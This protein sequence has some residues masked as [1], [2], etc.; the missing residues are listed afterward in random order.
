[1]PRDFINDI[2]DRA[3]S[4]N[5]KI[6]L[7][8]GCGHCASS[9]DLIAHLSVV[10]IDLNEK[11]VEQARKIYGNAI[12]LDMKKAFEHF[13]EKSFDL[14]FSLD[15]LE[16]LVKEDSVK[17]LQDSEKIARN[18]VIHFIPKDALKMVNR[19]KIKVNKG[20]QMH[21]CEWTQEELEEFGYKVKYYGEPFNHFLAEKKL[22]KE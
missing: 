20:L 16:H 13:G 19:K 15:S 11:E 3:R 21:R 7:D 9:S 5:C 22:L 8:L 14:V 10:G 1:M 17:V 6:A 2:I 4:Y 12:K 18:Y